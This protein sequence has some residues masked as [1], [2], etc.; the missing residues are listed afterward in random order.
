[1][2][3]EH[4]PRK[5]MKKKNIQQLLYVHVHFFLSFIGTFA[6]A[7]LLF[8]PF[9]PLNPNILTTPEALTID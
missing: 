1:M 6:L 7:A 9:R 2:G 5:E 8:R 4:V 3:L